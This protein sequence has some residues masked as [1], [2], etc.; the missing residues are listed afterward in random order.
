MKQGRHLSPILLLFTTQAFLEPVKEYMLAKTKPEFRTNT[1]I[2]KGGKSGEKYR[3]LTGR[4]KT[5]LLLAPGPCCTGDAA[6][7][8][9]ERPDWLRQ[10][11]PT[12]TCATSCAF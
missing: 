12:T 2:M 7:L 5:S 9:P 8:C 6:S 4:A 10:T 1:R 11:Q 3:A